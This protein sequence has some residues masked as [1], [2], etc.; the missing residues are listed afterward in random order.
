MIEQ[1]QMEIIDEEADHVFSNLA[2]FNI[3]AEEVCMGFGIRD[4]RQPQLVSMHTYLHLTV[5]HFLRFAETV[6]QQI[7]LLIE[8]GV[9]SPREPEQ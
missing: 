6:N 3:N 1:E 7:N 5:P 8:R 4:V 9:I 2:S